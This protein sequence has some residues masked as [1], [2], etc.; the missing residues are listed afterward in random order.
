MRGIKY[1]YDFVKPDKSIITFTG[2]TMPEVLANVKQLTKTHYD[3]EFKIS[4]DTIYNIMRR[5]DVA[6]KFYASKLVVRKIEKP[7][8]TTTYTAP[9]PTNPA[10]FTDITTQNENNTQQSV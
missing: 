10:I 6:H 7:T 3:I 5:P 2:H 8:T 4:R 1:D 9:A